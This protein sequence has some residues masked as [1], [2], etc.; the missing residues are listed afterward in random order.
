MN[1]TDWNAA[2]AEIAAAPATGSYT[3]EIGGDFGVAG[4][5]GDANTFAANRTITIKGNNNTIHLTGNGILLE[6]GGFE[7]HT[8]YMENL[9]LVGRLGN[10]HALVNINGD[11]RFTMRGSS[12]ISGN[13]NTI[14]AGGVFIQW[15]TF[16]MEGGRIF[17]NT[18]GHAGGVNV[19]S[20]ST[21]RLI[22]GTV[23]GSSAGDNS[24]IRTEAGTGASLR[25]GTGATATY[26][27]GNT[28]F[29]LNHAGTDSTITG[30]GIQ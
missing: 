11:S 4:L 8:V 22:N 16:I 6:M 13:K 25:V 3:I 30:E 7:P 2:R 12:S 5:T 17:G 27:S 15:G 21:F 20:G 24:N 1:E 14:W 19:F 9:N 23:Y 26:G 28:S 29:G 18:G 10:N